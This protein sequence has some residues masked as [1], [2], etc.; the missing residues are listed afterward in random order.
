MTC[1]TR[2]AALPCVDHSQ[3]TKP[4]L[5]PPPLPGQFF[6]CSSSEAILPRDDG[7]PADRGAEGAT[8]IQCRPGA[9]DAVSLSPVAG[10]GG[11]YIG[12]DPPAFWCR[13]IELPHP[14]TDTPRG[15][16][17]SRPRWSGEYAAPF[18]AIRRAHGCVLA[19]ALCSIRKWAWYHI[20]GQRR[21]TIPSWK[22][23]SPV[24]STS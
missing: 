18:P 20:T 23:H 24:A 11:S 7:V 15:G 21:F 22:P 12:A 1:S 2:E 13:Q 16:L 3:S 10:Y 14:R 8:T 4:L 5:Q 6:F 9:G 19:G 17:P